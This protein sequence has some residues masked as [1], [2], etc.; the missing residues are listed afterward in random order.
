MN[1]L[2]IWL[3]ALLDLTQ[4]HPHLLF[5]EVSDFQKP[6]TIIHVDHQYLS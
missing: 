2:I 4:L 5:G 1:S 6:F 3:L